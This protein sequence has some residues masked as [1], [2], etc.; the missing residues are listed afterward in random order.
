MHRVHLDLIQVTLKRLRMRHVLSVCSY[1][2]SSGVVSF[3]QVTAERHTFL[4]RHVTRFKNSVFVKVLNFLQA[5]ADEYKKIRRSISNILKMWFSS[6]TAR[7]DYW[8]YHTLLRYQLVICLPNMLPWC[9]HSYVFQS[10]KIQQCTLSDRTSYVSVRLS[11]C[12]IA[13]GQTVWCGI[14]KKIRWNSALANFKWWNYSR[15]KCS[16]KSNICAIKLSYSLHGFSV[17]KCGVCTVRLIKDISHHLVIV[18]GGS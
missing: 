4:K 3:I 5:A 1:R 15:C 12:F 2:K 14:N 17:S 16:S 9:H 8:W 11:F 6:W 13:A 18:H 7:Y 10:M